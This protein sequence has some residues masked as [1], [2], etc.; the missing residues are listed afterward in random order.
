MWVCVILTVQ[1][2]F[3]FLLTMNF[4]Y[5][6]LSIS[7]SPPR[8]I[9]FPCCHK[10]GLSLK[11][12]E[13]GVLAKLIYL[14]LMKKLDGK[15]N[16]LVSHSRSCFIFISLFCEIWYTFIKTKCCVKHH[17]N[18]C[19]TLSWFFICN[20]HLLFNC[21]ILLR[22]PLSIFSSQILID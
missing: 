19:L 3:E 4:I 7:I 20:Y 16:C 11:R 22:V 5:A 1:Q 12:V 10:R 14:K 15:Y 6:Y 18:F 9:Y 13:T 21:R 8:T 2:L 17:R